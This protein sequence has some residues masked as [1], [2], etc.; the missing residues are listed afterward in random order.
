MVKD[1]YQGWQ[2]LRLQSQPLLD[3]FVDK[4]VSNWLAPMLIAAFVTATIK[5][6]PSAYVSWGEYLSILVHAIFVLCPIYLCK[7]LSIRSQGARKILWWVLGFVIIPAATFICLNNEV[8][9]HELI[10]VGEQGLFVLWALEF[11][12]LI[13]LWL[14]SRLK[15]LRFKPNLD[16]VFFIL[17]IGV[18]FFMAA[19][20]N[21]IDD[22]LEHQPIHLVIDLKRNVLLFASFLGYLVQ[23]LVLYGSLY[24]AYY[25][26]HHL[27]INKVLQRHGVYH[28][29]WVTTLFLL[30]CTPIVTQIVMWMPLNIADYTVTASTDYNPFSLYNLHLGLLIIVLSFPLILA[31][32]LQSDN[33]KLAE[34]E[35]EKLATELKWLQQQINPHFLFNTLNN[36]YALCLAKSAQA[37]DLILQLANLLRFVVYKGGNDRVSL[38]DEIDYL[39]DYIDLQRLRVENKCQI[40]IDF[41]QATKPLAISPLLLIIFIENAF[42]HGVE[43]SAQQSTIDVRLEVIDNKLHFHCKNSMPHQ[44][45]SEDQG[46]GLENVRRR[47]ALSYPDKHQLVVKQQEGFYCV[48]LILDL[49]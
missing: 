1:L 16:N 19:V 40:S 9:T 5:V 36:L 34:L 13:R 38:T 24:L 25:V 49:A 20:F 15:A 4:L 35:Q 23:F 37:P 12:A 32:K 14:G 45:A 2:Q 22:P 33:R 26:N 27:L 41:N 18:S 29:L 3:K 7:Y 43:V 47:L 21:S 39:N 31:M 11:S 10:I 17:W 46:I 48:D 44:V 30:I 42:K 6:S 28:Y 8:I